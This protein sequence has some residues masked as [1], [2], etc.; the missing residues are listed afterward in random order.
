[1]SSPH[2]LDPAS[3]EEYLAGRD[4]LVAAG[5]LAE[6]GQVRLLRPGGGGQGRR[7]GRRGRGPQAA[8]VPGQHRAAASR[9]TWSCRSPTPRWSARAPWTR[10]GRPDAHP[11]ERLRPGG[12]DHQGRPGLA[13]GHGQAGLPRPQQDPD[14]PDHRGRV[15]AA[16]GRPA[17]DGPGA[18]V[19]PGARARPGLGAPG[20]RR[21]RLRGPDREEGLQG[22]RRVRAPGARRSPAT[23]TTRPSAARTGPRS[24]RSRSPSRRGQ[25]SPWTGTRC[26]GRTGRC[27]SASTPARA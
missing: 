21:G 9:P 7:A 20:R 27:G 15:R 5:L 18:G 10:P 6:T 26:A 23:T 12:R 4:I 19:R 16:R 3:A 8:R 11:G 13:R 14:G 17:A 2:P 22:H 25:A 24:S 1:M